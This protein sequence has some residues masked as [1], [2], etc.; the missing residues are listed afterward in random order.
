[1]ADALEK[2]SVNVTRLSANVQQ[3]LTTSSTVKGSTPSRI[4]QGRRGI[5]AASDVS[6]SFGEFQALGPVNVHIEEGEF[7]SILGPSGC[8]KSTL[9]LIVAGLLQ[10]SK[11]HVEV[12][13]TVLKRPMTDVGIVFQDHLLLEFR[14][15][16]ENVLLQQEI[17]GLDR[18]QIRKRAQELYA[19]ARIDSPRPGS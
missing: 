14:T 11:G 16:F 8:G 2:R 12:K 6:K 5:I 7:V 10:P 18:N 17:R 1:M 13:G 19:A 15:A 3:I 4:E 9:M